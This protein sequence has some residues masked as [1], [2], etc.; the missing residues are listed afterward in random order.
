MGLRPTTGDAKTNGTSFIRDYNRP[1]D[2]NVEFLNRF[3]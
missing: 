1:G 3:D 2:D